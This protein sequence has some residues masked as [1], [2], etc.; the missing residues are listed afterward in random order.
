MKNHLE[1]YE[2]LISHRAIETEL[3]RIEATEKAENSPIL[4]STISNVKQKR[5]C[6]P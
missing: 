6:V 5:Y 3:K 4:R 1:K 2:D